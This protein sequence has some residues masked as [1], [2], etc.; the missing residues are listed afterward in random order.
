MGRES[1]THTSGIS[2]VHKA[3]SV[4]EITAI[5][6]IFELQTNSPNQDVF[7]YNPTSV[8]K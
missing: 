8:F 4:G 1:A 2:Q 3:K 7:F 6:S 5:E